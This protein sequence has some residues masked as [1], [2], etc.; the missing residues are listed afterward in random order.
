MIVAIYVIV[1]IVVVDDNDNLIS[2]SISSYRH[3]TATA[4]G[5]YCSLSRYTFY[6]FFCLYPC[7]QHYLQLPLMT[8]TIFRTV[9]ATANSS[10]DYPTS[11]SS[12]YIHPCCVCRHSCW[13]CCTVSTAAASSFCLYLAAPAISSTAADADDECNGN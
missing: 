4:T 10:S 11:C 7:R 13:S 6:F 8:N 1:V 2:C 9:S 12:P 3:F 5:E